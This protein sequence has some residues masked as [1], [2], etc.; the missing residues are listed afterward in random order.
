MAGRKAEV[1]AVLF[2]TLLLSLNSDQILTHLTCVTSNLGCLIPAGLSSTVFEI[3]THTYL[4]FNRT[5]YLFTFIFR[6]SVHSIIRAWFTGHHY[7][8]LLKKKALFFF[9]LFFQVHVILPFASVLAESLA[10]SFLSIDNVER[11]SC[12]N[13]SFT[14]WCCLILPGWMLPFLDNCYQDTNFFP[15][16]YNCLFCIIELCIQTGLLAV[17]IV[18]QRQW[19]DMVDILVLMWS[20]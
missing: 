4:C 10:V 3:Y 5:L 6:L 13:I 2:L 14:L 16:I 12:W 1:H 20:L 19:L 15:T 17:Y 7:L 11:H 18:L 9:A 8:F